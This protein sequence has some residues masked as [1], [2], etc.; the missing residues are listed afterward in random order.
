MPR[1]HLSRVAA[2]GLVL[3]TLGF[4]LLCALPREQPPTHSSSASTSTTKPAF[5]SLL[6]RSLLP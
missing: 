2:I 3:A 4:T 6:P 5:F 1:R